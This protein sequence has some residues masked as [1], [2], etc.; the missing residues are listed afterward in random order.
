MAHRPTDRPT[1]TDHLLRLLF[2]LG[3]EKEEEEKVLVNDERTNVG[4]SRFKES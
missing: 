1:T 2:L 4:V 3:Q